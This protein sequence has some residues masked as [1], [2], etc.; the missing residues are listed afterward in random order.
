MKNVWLT[1]ALVFFTGLVMAQDKTSEVKVW[2]NCGMCKKRIEKAAM[3]EGVSKATWDKTTKMLTLVYDDSKVTTADVEKK[4][5]AV[6]HDTEHFYA[7][8]KTYDGLP[9]CCLYDRKPKGKKDK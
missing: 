4:V 8:A 9:E 3:L 6:G 1:V 5:A 2:G 7:E